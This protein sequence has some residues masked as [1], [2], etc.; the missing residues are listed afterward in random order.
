VSFGSSGNAGSAHLAGEMLRVATGLDMVHIPYKGDA[1]AVTDLLAGNITCLF[2]S[3]PSVAQHVKA[4]RLK[5]LAIT[6]ATRI[7]ALP[8]LPTMTEAGV[9]GVEVYLWFGIMGPANLSREVVDILS[10]EILQMGRL[11]DV[12]DLIRSQGGEPYPLNPVELTAFIKSER[13]KYGAVIRK[14]NIKLE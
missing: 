13:A 8:D 2:V 14:A 10:R 11:P 4:G 12:V 6:G 5:A 1:P 3:A 9:P 7:S